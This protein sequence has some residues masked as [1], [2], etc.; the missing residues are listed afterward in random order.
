V[1]RQSQIEQMLNLNQSQ[2]LANFQALWNKVAKGHLPQL[3]Q[4]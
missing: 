1:T 2:S 4:A 3:G